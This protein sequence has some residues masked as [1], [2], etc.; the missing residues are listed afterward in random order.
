MRSFDLLKTYRRPN[1]IL[2]L[3]YFG[4]IALALIYTPFN[5]EL[6][7]TLL[8]A[9]GTAFTE[10]NFSIIGDAYSGG[11]ILPAIGLTLVTNLLLGSL[12]SIT[13][14]SLIVPFSG[15]L[16]GLFRALMW[17]ILFSPSL[18]GVGFGDIVAGFLIVI[19]LLLEGQAYV[20]TM[21]AAY[22]QGKAFLFP[23]SVGAPNR[24]SGYWTGVKQSL[25]LYPLVTLVLVAAAVYEAVIA[26][27]ILPRIG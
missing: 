2:N 18:S 3:L 7:K 19:L 16:V 4:S 12:V 10:G 6:Q 25:R 8:D 1:I 26:I 22:I 17:G 14:P 11:Q 5:R 13:L 24:K 15:L 23:D 21:L 27:L 9:A 20:L